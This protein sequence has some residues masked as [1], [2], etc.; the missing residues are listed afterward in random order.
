[1]YLICRY[2]KLDE[3]KCSYLMLLL[4]YERTGLAERRHSIRQEL[5]KIQ[6]RH[7]Q[8]EA[9]LSEDKTSGKDLG[10]VFPEYYLEPL[11]QLVHI[12][13][14]IERFAKS[15]NALAESLG[16]PMNKVQQI[17]NKLLEKGLIEKSKDRYKN[18]RRNSHL[19][20]SSP[21]FRAW[22]HQLNSMA[23]A[24]LQQTSGDEH[25]GFTAVFSADES[26]RKRMQAKVLELIKGFELE[27]K[28]APPQGV[29][30]FSIDLLPWML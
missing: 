20:K 4:E 25:Y 12:A 13:V 6:A 21:V 10:E 15:P 14:S 3:D 8:T 17:L 29:Y 9:H 5:D 30:Q 18:V 7:L 16:V 19:K 27:V 11:H 22:R 1:M 2:L 26:A 23:N 28:H 24:R